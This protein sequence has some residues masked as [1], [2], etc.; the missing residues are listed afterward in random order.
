MSATPSPRIAA[1]VHDHSGE[2]D[3]LL[4]AF[5]ARQLAAGI[6][7]RG[8][9]HLPHEPTANGKR[10]ALMDVTDPG[11]RYPISQAP[12]PA[13]CGCSLAPGGLAHAR[14]VR[15]RAPQDA[16]EL[17]TANRLGVPKSGL[18]GASGNRC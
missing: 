3:A 6:R 17:G 14:G 9:V 13:S 12:R 11:S 7:V 2:P 8:L 4:A 16:A 1:I 15:R 18:C 5:A 10:M